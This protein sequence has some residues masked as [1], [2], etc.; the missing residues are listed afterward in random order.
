MV[1]DV[2]ADRLLG[3]PVA[4]ELWWWQQADPAAVE[5]FA[6]NAA[7]QLVAASQKPSDFIQNDEAWW[8]QAYSAGRGR[9]YI[10]DP[11]WDA[12]ARASVLAVAVPIRAGAQPGARVVGILKVLL[13]VRSLFQEIGRTGTADSGVLALTDGAGK[14]LA[15]QRPIVNPARGTGIERLRAEPSGWWLAR[16]DGDSALV[17]W[18]KVGLSP[19]LDAEAVRSPAL[20]VVGRQNAAVAFGPLR[21]VQSWMIVISLMTIIT[22]TVLGYWLTELL[23]VRQIRKLA[24]GMRQLARGDFD[25]AAGIAAELTA[26]GKQ[27]AAPADA[28]LPEADRSPTG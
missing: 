5:L 1:P 11:E 17:A 23:V 9:I 16:A 2:R 25:R 15:S 13:S 12:S 28:A 20:Y 19:R 10:S 26:N 14:V 8:Q 27:T 7:G 6:T 18:A 21:R 24:A 4:R 3:N 22:A